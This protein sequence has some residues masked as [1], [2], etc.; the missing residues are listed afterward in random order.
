VFASAAMVRAGYDFAV[1]AA[2]VD[3]GVE[4]GAVVGV[5]DGASEVV[6]GSDGSVLFIKA[7]TKLK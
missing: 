4:T 5:G 3:T 6:F 1:G 2:D 7:T